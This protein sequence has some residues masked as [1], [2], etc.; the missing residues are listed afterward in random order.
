MNLE[1]KLKEEKEELKKMVDEFNQLQTTYKETLDKKA[2]D[3]IRK[4]GAI[5]ILQELINKGDK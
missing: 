2:Q 4:D 5:K 1:K 3:I